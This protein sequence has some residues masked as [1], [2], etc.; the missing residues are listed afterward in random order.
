MS[1][2]G[3]LSPIAKTNV[4]ERSWPVVGLRMGRSST[5]PRVPAAKRD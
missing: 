2:S 4:G 3:L 1:A 5:V